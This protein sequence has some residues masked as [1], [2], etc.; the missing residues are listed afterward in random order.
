MA[1]SGF[2]KQI[3]T[4]LLRDVKVKYISENVEVGSLIGQDENI[5]YSGSEVVTVGRLS[6]DSDNFD[7]K[8]NVTA[9]ST[10]GKKAFVVGYRFHRRRRYR[11]R[12]NRRCRRL[13]RIT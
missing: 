4:P 1:H 3:A 2:Y 13:Q 6:N 12:R 10:L 7:V 9:Q 8:A 11:R 5:Y